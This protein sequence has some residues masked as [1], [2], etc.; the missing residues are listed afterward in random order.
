MKG[1]RGKKPRKGRRQFRPVANLGC[2]K[3][4]AFKDAV[5]AQTVVDVIVQRVVYI[6]GLGI[7]VVYRC[8]RCGYWHFGRSR[9]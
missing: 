2:S 4:H 6:N 5:A 1:S 9:W 3:K 7:P 8:G